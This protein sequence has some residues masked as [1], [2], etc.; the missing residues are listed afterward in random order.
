MIDIVS[1][2]IDPMG[3][4]FIIQYALERIRIGEHGILPG[5]L[6]NTNDDIAL[7]VLIQ[8]PGVIQP[9]QVLQRR[10]K[11]NVIVHI[12][13]D[14]RLKVKQARSGQSLRQIRPGAGKR[15]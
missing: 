10:V 6:S 11:V 15:S 4:T 5:A 2:H 1:P 12:I 8:E 14:K 7:A 13:A 3:D 9:G